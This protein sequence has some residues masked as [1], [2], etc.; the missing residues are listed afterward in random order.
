MSNPA[1]VG[2]IP[3]G[4]IPVGTQVLGEPVTLKATDVENEIL[5]RQNKSQEMT[6]VELRGQCQNFANQLAGLKLEIESK[7]KMNNILSAEIRELNE[8]I[9]AKSI[10]LKAAEECIENMNRKDRLFVKMVEDR[11]NSVED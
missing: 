7:H 1:A 3:N 5:K 6:I 8:V 4:D 9:R 2:I 11:F 10:A